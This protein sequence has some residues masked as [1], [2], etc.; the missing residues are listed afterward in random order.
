VALLSRRTFLRQASVAA[1]AVPL[2]VAVAG[3]AT[4]APSLV[5]VDVRPRAAWAGSLPTPSLPQERPGDVRFLLVH[6]SASSN[7]YATP[8]VPGVI[9]GFHALH[10]GPKGWPDVAYNFFV[11]RFGGVWEGRAGSLAGPVLADATGGSQGF[12]Q[13]CCFIGDHTAEPPTAEARRS[14]TA[15]LAALSARYGIDPSPGA[16]TTFVSRGS[17]RWPAGTEVTAA[18][19][20]GHRDMSLTECPGDAAS[21]LVTGEFPTAVTAVLAARTAPPSAP[22]PTAAPR[23]SPAPVPTSASREASGPTDDGVSPTAVGWLAGGGLVAAAATV[24]GLRR[25]RGGMEQV[26]TQDRPCG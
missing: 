19:I 26:S 4:A 8:D 12:A 14:M 3:S 10:T 2:G 20:A 21:T 1:L 23:P 6:H 13:L 25:T 11:D 18:T 7:S 9:R 16:T 22:P 17:N 15:L 5:G 24:A